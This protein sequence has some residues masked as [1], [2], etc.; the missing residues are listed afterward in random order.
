MSDVSQSDIRRLKKS[1]LIIVILGVSLG[2]MYMNRTQSY[3]RYER[4]PFESGGATLYANLLYPSNNVTF[5][6]KSPLLIYAHGIGYQR[7]IDLRIPIEFTKRGFYVAAI[8]YQGH[9]ESGGNIDYVDPDTKIPALAQDC[10]KLLD[11]LETLPFYSYINTSQIGLIGHSLGGF[12]VLMNQALDPRFNAT[13]AWAPLV[14]P[15]GSDIPVG[16]DYKDYHPVNLLDENNTKNLLIISHVDDE[17]LSHGKNAVVAQQLTGC[18]LIEINYPLLGGGHTLLTDEVLIE[19][20]NWFETIFFGSET[21]NG[22]IVITFIF[23]YVFIFISLFALFM[24]TLTMINYSS[25]YFH[26]IGGYER[27]KKKKKGAIISKMGI[28]LQWAKIIIS[29]SVFISIWLFFQY[30]FGLYGLFYASLFMLVIYTI[31]KLYVN[32][33]KS[34]SFG[35]KFDLK[36]HIRENFDRNALL[37]TL[38]A[39]GYYIGLILLF[40]FFYP[41]AFTFPSNTLTIVMA[42]TSFPLYFSL[43]LL[44]R[45]VIYRQLWFVKTEKEKAKIIA[46]LAI[47]LQIILISWTLSWSVIPVVIITHVIFLASVIYNT[48]IYAETRN[49]SSIVLC[50]FI[51]NVIFFGAIVSQALGFG[52]TLHYLVQF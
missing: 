43:E 45:K 21:I 36:T 22:P 18:E 33:Q 46:G 12:T 37:F 29:I 24:A 2:L 4:I 1:V 31:G 9:G 3:Y 26:F 47:I 23:N 17:A 19:S 20:I 50:S 10:S 51:T 34:K 8:D 15:V 14:D 28:R 39:T 41:F 32:H 40:T 52:A 16:Q 27:K 49:F 38:F 5:Q 44:Y 13:V 42:L 35:K 11:K 7:D 48:A 30:F 6:E 25:K